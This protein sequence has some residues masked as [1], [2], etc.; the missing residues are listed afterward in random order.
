MAG[1]GF[2]PTEIVSPSSRHIDQRNLYR[3]DFVTSGLRMFALG[4]GEQ[5]LGCKFHLIR[6]P[7]LHRTVE[8]T[9]E[10]YV[11]EVV[12]ERIDF[13]N[14]MLP[15]F[16]GVPGLQT[17]LVYACSRA[18]WSVRT[19]TKHSQTCLKNPLPD[20]LFHA[21]DRSTLSLQHHPGRVLRI[22]LQL[23]RLW[24]LPWRRSSIPKT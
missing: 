10:D 1:W 18:A 13:V 17:R 11:S 3:P 8:F 20:F 4:I 21:E 12:L 14:S 23:L 2:Y 9:E 19:M 7:I 15:G 16:D 22:A 6:T 24:S 5:H